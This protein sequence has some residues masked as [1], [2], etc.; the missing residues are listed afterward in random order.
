MVHLGALGRSKA[1]ER[2][3]ASLVMRP[4]RSNG[5]PQDGAG[6]NARQRYSLPLRVFTGGEGLALFDLGL[7]ETGPVST[8]SSAGDQLQPR[9]RMEGAHQQVHRDHSTQ[10]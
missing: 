7:V 5:N 10:W 9:H 2:S 3:A 4:W 1:F 6:W 8:A